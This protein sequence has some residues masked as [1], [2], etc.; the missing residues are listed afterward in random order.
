MFELLM[1]PQSILLAQVTWGLSLVDCRHL[2]KSAEWHIKHQYKMW[3]KHKLLSQSNAC[4]KI[5]W[6]WSACYS[7][8]QFTWHIGLQNIHMKCSVKLAKRYPLIKQA[9]W[10]QL[11][12]KLTPASD[13][14]GEMFAVC[15]CDALPALRSLVFLAMRQDLFFTSSGPPSR[16]YCRP[17]PR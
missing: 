3:K 13:H 12:L 5:H 1:L 8:K 9:N 11:C 15:C 2:F 16:P 6:D 10:P 7:T 14:L 17:S 4:C